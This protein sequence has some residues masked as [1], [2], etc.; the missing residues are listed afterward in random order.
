MPLGVL[1]PA[2][3]IDQKI[4]QPQPP[5]ARS[6]RSP[7]Q[8]LPAASSLAVP[9]EAPLPPVRASIRPES[10]AWRLGR[11]DPGPA[12]GT[13]TS[14]L[15]PVVRGQQG[16]PRQVDQRPEWPKASPACAINGEFA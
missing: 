8:E 12:D 9:G 13:A 6:A 4:D 5:A 16:H 15:A 11:P 1:S 2:I 10:I 7:D 3:S 14:C